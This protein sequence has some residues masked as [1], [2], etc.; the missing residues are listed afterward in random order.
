MAD[1]CYL[2]Q[3]PIDFFQRND[4]VYLQSLGNGNE[5]L[6]IYIKLMLASADTYGVV[7][8]REK[9]LIDLTGEDM[10]TLKTIIPLLKEYGFLVEIAP[11]FY[12]IKDT[13]QDTVLVRRE[14]SDRDRNSAQYRAWRNAVFERDKYTCQKCG[15]MG[16]KLNAH[17]IKPWAKFE[18]LRFN[19]DNGIT[20]CE[21]C[22]KKL[23]KRR[24]RN[25]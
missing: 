20:Y 14:L 25:G 6:L 4:V 22:H 12:H 8:R 2:V 3:L 23:H 5:A 11:Y 1:K 10:K 16:V 7:S 18:E 13:N 9:N 17:H 15:M 21:K 24:V 19:I